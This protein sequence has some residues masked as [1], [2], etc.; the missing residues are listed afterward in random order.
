MDVKLHNYLAWMQR[1]LQSSELKNDEERLAMVK[2]YLHE[3][4][5]NRHPEY[6]YLDALRYIM[7]HG[8]Q[9]KL[10]L[11]PEVEQQ[12][13]NKGLPIPTI[14]SR[15]GEVRAV[16]DLSKGLP[17]LTTKRTFFKGILI[18]LLWFLKGSDDIRYLQ[19]NGVKIWDEWQWK[20]YVNVQKALGLEFLEEQDFYK[21]VKE[22]AE[23][24]AKHCN[25]GAPYG[26]NWR[27]FKGEG[28]READ[29][30]KWLINSLRKNPNRKCYVGSGWHPAYIY[31]MALPGESI[32]L[33]A[34]HT[35]FHFNVN[36]GKL[37][38]LMYQRSAD[39][40]LGVPFNIASYAILLLMFSQVTEIPPRRFI[41][42]FGDS[43]IYSNT[44]DQVNEQLSREPR[45]F[46]TLKLNSSITDIDDFKFEDFEL[47]GYDPHPLLKGEVVNVGGY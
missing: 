34:C 41:H 6:Q 4:E 46:P 9:K 7:N 14:Q 11:K 44:F 29:Q 38:L 32:E 45:P 22:D 36:D 23:F 12:Y 17:L 47:I 27:H 18:E 37:D 35:F 31:E 24:N 26:V 21:K 19:E 30:I 16:Y 43:H 2:R 1:D 15:F 25:S 28:N 42:L 39:M 8:D 13:I 3:Y 10:T 40:F 5:E 33:P 20:K